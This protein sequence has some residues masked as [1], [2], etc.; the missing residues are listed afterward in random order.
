MDIRKRRGAQKRGKKASGKCTGGTGKRERAGKK[1]GKKKGLSEYGV[2][3][4]PTH[5]RS[6]RGRFLT[7]AQPTASGHWTTKKSG[8]RQEGKHAE[9][10]DPKISERGY[11]YDE[12]HVTQHW[13]RYATPYHDDDGGDWQC[14]REPAANTSTTPLQQ[15]QYIHHSIRQKQCCS[16]AKS[17]NISRLNQLKRTAVSHKT[18][19]NVKKSVHHSKIDNTFKYNLITAL[20]ANIQTSTVE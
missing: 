5:N 19:L 16:T 10:T 20:T 8:K 4:H 9:G 2:T 7:A 18:M 15:F 1:S 13:Q 17:R 12:N 6:F 14:R 3:S 11:A